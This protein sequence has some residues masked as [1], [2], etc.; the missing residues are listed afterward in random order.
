M[1]VLC[2]S[3]QTFMEQLEARGAPLFNRFTA[4]LIVR[5]LSYLESAEFVPSLSASDKALVSGILGGTPFNLD[6][7]DAGRDVR[8]NLMHLFADP[9]SPLVDSPD[10]ILSA[11]LPDPRVAYRVL[12]GIALGHSRWA[13]IRD[14]AKVHDRVLPRL[15]DVGLIERHVPVTEDPLKSRRSV[16]RIPDPYLRFW[17]RF[18]LR[19]R[20]AIERGLGESLVKEKIVPLLDDSMGQT[21]EDMAREF[22]LGLVREGRKLLGGLMGKYTNSPPPL[23]SN[24]CLVYDKYGS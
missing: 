16:Y 5:P 2:G 13:E 10:R 9:M 23:A 18:I 4:K 15:L 24:V 14:Y 11:D 8:A 1:L 12:Q 21:F 7:W 22:T 17:F 6:Q 3:A 20:G 19:N